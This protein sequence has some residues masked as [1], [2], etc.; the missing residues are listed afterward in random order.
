MLPRKILNYTFNLG[1]KLILHMWICAVVWI[2][3]ARVWNFI[4]VYLELERY[5]MFTCSELARSLRSQSAELCILS[6]RSRLLEGGD[7]PL[8]YVVLAQQAV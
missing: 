4:D 8:P 3:H 6:F 7:P 2:A 5:G 1:A